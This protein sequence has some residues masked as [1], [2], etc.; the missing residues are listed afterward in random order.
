MG[1]ASANRKIGRRQWLVRGTFGGFIDHLSE[2]H[3]GPPL[4]AAHEPP[5]KIVYKSWAGVSGFRWVEA[6]DLFS[7]NLAHSFR[8]YVA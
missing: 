2:C 1:L 8:K 5:E 6:V 4:F 7:C 3:E